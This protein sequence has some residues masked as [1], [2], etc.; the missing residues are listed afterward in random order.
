MRSLQPRR[1]ARTPSL[2]T[3]SDEA[4]PPTGK[5]VLTRRRFQRLSDLAVEIGTPVA[6]A[7]NLPVHLDVPGVAWFV[8]RGALDVFLVEYQDGEPSSHAKHVLRAEEGRLVFGVG[9]SKSLA[10]IAKGNPDCRLRRVHLDDALRYEIVEQLAG[11]VDAWVVEFAAAVAAQIEPRPRPN[12]LLDPREPPEALDVPDGWVVSSRPGGVVWVVVENAD[13]TYLGTEER[14]TTGSGVIPL[15]SATWLTLQSPACIAGHASRELCN[16]GILLQTLAEFHQLILGA[17]QIS[18]LLLLADEANEQTAR[19]LHRQ[20]DE[21][22]AR[23]S[24]FG[25]LGSPYPA[26]NESGS[27]LLAALQAIGKREGIAFRPPSRRRVSVDEELSLREIL[28]TSGIRSRK[29]QLTVEERW[30]E[31]DSGA[32]LGFRH[33]DGRPL[34]LLPS[35]SGRYRA[36]DP[37]TGESTRLNAERAAGIQQDGWL[38][39]RPLPDDRPVGTKDILRLATQGMS[40]DLGQFAGAGVIASL[41][42]LAPAIAIGLLATWVLPAAV[43]RMLAQIVVVLLV[44][45]LVGTLLHVLRGTAMMRVE[46][47]ATARVSAALWD[48]LLGL[49]TRFFRNF[50]A[51]ELAVRM[52][53]FQALRDQV[54]GV[55]ANAVIS[56]LF[57]LPMLILLFAYDTALAWLILGT[58]MLSLAIMLVFGLLQVGPQRRFYAISRRLAGELFQFINGIGKLRAAGAEA[59][60][61][62]AWARGYREQQLAQLQI[63]KLNEHLVA[64]SAAM[65]AFMGAAIFGVAL[66]H[67]PDRLA[68]GDFLVVYAVSITFYASVVGLGYSF[69]VIAAALPGYEQVKPILTAVPDRRTAPAAPI[70]LSGEVR[71]DHVSFQYTQDGPQIIDNV[72]IHARPGEFIAIVGESGAGKS[73]LLRLALGLEAPSAGGVYYDGRDL[74][75][76][77]RRSVCRRIGVVTQDGA[78]KPGNLLDNIIGFGDDLTIDDAWR[79]AKLAAVDSDIAAMPMQMFTAVGDSA[80]TFSGGQ[81]QRIR[82]AAALV[83]EPR[84]VFLDEATSWL[85]AKSQAQVMKGIAS[86][87]ATRIVIAHRLSTIRMAERIYV[88]HEGRVVQEGSF[89]ALYQTEGIFRDLVQ[90]QMT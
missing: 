83:R 49:P 13:A 46:G 77:D 63:G 62:A 11:Q 82:I 36:L 73:T 47:R 78:L 90:R 21:E 31:G 20:R 89:I 48:R 42:M 6:S 26:A 86:L 37:V 80:A 58:G 66:W 45:A 14:D 12:V 33:E 53:A 54:S 29:V 64:F 34:A 35:L 74:A 55:V 25:V 76:L 30:W 67:G 81:I 7:G 3:H 32:M 24:L 72:S 15:T 16:Q 88:L 40:S 65:P 43:E 70:D 39:Y 18:R 17:E 75:H 5:A 60:A 56:F 41:L 10:T 2:S 8:E 4:Y 59:S 57:L 22:R 61:F 71:F 52:A 9:E 87:A 19:T 38:F 50:T 69:E 51:G 23:Q 85:D 28:E 68:L 84:I 27:A 1:K 79:A 44:L